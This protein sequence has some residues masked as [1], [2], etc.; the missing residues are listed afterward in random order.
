MRRTWFWIAALFVICLG[1]VAG[2]KADPPSGPIKAPTCGDPKDGQACACDPGQRC[3]RATCACGFL[4]TPQVILDDPEPVGVSVIGAIDFVGNDRLVYQRREPTGLE[5]SNATVNRYGIAWPMPQRA[6]AC[7]SIDDCFDAGDDL[8]DTA[9]HG[10][11]VYELT[12]V[13]EHPDGSAICYTPCANHGAIATVLCQPDPAPTTPEDPPPPDPPDTP[14]PDT[15]DTVVD[16]PDPTS[17][18]PEPL[19]DQDGGCDE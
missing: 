7:E 3:D 13:V 16:E 19:C 18:T 10:G 1:V 11:A 5:F 12:E 15:P 6:R 2:T 4:V 8:C 17:I 9:G 14:P